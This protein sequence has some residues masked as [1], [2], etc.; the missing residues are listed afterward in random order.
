LWLMQDHEACP[1]PAAP[2][3]G[4]RQAFASSRQTSEIIALYRAPVTLPHRTTDPAIGGDAGSQA[5]M[6]APLS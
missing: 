3:S 4:R 6:N 5:F 2:P 1:Q